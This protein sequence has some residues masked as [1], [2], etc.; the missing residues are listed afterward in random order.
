MTKF[1]R[2]TTR[3]LAVGVIVVLMLI[4]FLWHTDS[5]GWGFYVDVILLAV[6][7]VGAG[8]NARGTPKPVGA[9][10]S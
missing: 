5:L 1:G 10:S 4:R 6:V 3:A 7:A 2:E 8:L 9:R